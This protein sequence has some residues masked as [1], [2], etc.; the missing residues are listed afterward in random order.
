ME[1]AHSLIISHWLFVTVGPMT[2]PCLQSLLPARTTTAEEVEEVTSMLEELQVTT[3]DLMPRSGMWAYHCMD[4]TSSPTPSTIE[5]VLPSEWDNMPL[6]SCD[7]LTLE[8]P[9]LRSP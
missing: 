3:T 4:D 6:V 7:S 5:D 1:S 2:T 9:H 8:K